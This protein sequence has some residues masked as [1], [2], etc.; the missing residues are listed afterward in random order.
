[1]AQVLVLFLLIFCVACRPR[2]G[3]DTTMPPLSASVTM[4]ASDTNSPVLQAL[5]DAVEDYSRSPQAWFQRADWYLKKGD[6]Q[7][8]LNDIN[9]AIRL[10][11]NNSM[12][13]YL[14]AL[15]Y[16]R[17]GN[18]KAAW[19]SA[20]QAEKL[21]NQMPEF[22]L[23]M[24]ELS[25]QR[26]EYTQAQKYLG[27]ALEINPSAGEVYYFKAKVA[28]E[29][30]DT[31]QALQWYHQGLK[32]RPDYV[33]MYNRLAELANASR[34]YELALQYVRDGLRQDSL[35][36]LVS[37][38]AQDLGRKS[39]YANLFYNAG[40]SFKGL[41]K[42]DTAKYLFDKTVTIKPSF[43][44]ADYQLGLLYFNDKNY[45]KA[46]GHFEKV[47]KYQPQFR[48]TNYFLGVCY[49]QAGQLA[50]ASTELALARK[51]DP[52][53]NRIAEQSQK[54]SKLIAIQQYRQRRDSL[55]ALLPPAE[56]TPRRTFIPFEPI[57]PKSFEIKK[58][59]SMMKIGG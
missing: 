26:K 27:K 45:A 2:P 34:N 4:A 20:L 7:N 54:V 3:A 49:T 11:Q 32:K 40:N 13:H 5:T 29:T 59:T 30:G 56:R 41:N 25:Q 24:G 18:S 52:T 50:N 8:A 14:L 10:D 6:W 47:K 33:D 15:T 23:L 55:N 42:L 58:D 35:K 12:Y 57:A 31:T 9:W 36:A 1:M 17:L 38:Q 53:D 51:A 37:L 28:A 44:E 48:K 43:Y 19:E 21:N 16:Q 46:Q 39:A 22:F